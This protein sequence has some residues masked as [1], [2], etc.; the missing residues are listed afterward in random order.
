MVKRYAI[1][2]LEVRSDFPFTWPL[3]PA[4]HSGGSGGSREHLMGRVEF[5]CDDSFPPWIEDVPSS[6]PQPA[7][8]TAWVAGE[9]SDESP[10]LLRF[11][12]VTDHFIG[13]GRIHCRLLDPS[14]RYLVEIQLMGMVLAA[15]LTR[16]RFPVLHAAAVAVNGVGVA[17]AGEKG[18]GKST[19]AGALVAA[20]F[21][22]VA[23]DLLAFA[24]GTPGDAAPT[25]PWVHSGIPLVRVTAEQILALG[26]P[27]GTDPVHPA[28]EKRKVVLGREGVGFHHGGLP[29]KRVYLPCPFAGTGPGRE[30]GDRSDITFEPVASAHVLPILMGHTFLGDR[31]AAWGLAEVA[32][33]AWVGL[34]RHH[35][36]SLVR[37]HYP[38]GYQ[39][40]P[41][42]VAALTADATS[43]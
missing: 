15:W 23:D 43:T 27:D 7:G 41:D 9:G 30:E 36:I 14:N 37:L 22:L 19:L 1:Y 13:E 10:D 2:G 35:R 25:H 16:R 5:T 17:I 31:L 32:M 26:L 3:P 8:E 12:G 29:L 11:G 6:S 39:H 40:L 28:F 33:E 34:L 18:R 38:L 4:G 21:P 20:G 24:A 42:V